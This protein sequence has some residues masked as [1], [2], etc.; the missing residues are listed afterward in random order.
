VHSFRLVQDLD[1]PTLAVE[2][3]E[4]TT[5]ERL[6]IRGSAEPGSEL[7]IENERVP[8]AATGEFEYALQLNPGLNMIVIE[9]VDTAGNST[10]RS[11]YVTARF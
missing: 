4:A 2:L 1:P 8:L 9:A 3:P 11:Q 6:V 7:F 10:Y 5:S